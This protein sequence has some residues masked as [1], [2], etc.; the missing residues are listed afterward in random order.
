MAHSFHWGFAVHLSLALAFP[1]VSQYFIPSQYVA[2]RDKVLFPGQEVINHFLC[3]KNLLTRVS[4]SA[5]NEK[6]LIPRMTLFVFLIE[7]KP[8]H[9]A[10]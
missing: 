6:I 5:K 4:Y 3:E 7:I 10:Q 9:P 1:R 8:L 2:Q